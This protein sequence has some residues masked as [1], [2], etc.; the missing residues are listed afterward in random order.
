MSVMA[1]TGAP[2]ARTAA[3]GAPAPDLRRTRREKGFWAHAARRFLRNRLANLG[4]AIVSTLTFMAI[5][6]PLVTAHHYA[7][8]MFG[9]AWRFPSGEFWM[10]TDGIGRDFFSR[11]VY[12]TRVSLSVGL[13]AQL[14]SF[15]IGVPL[16]ILAGLKGGR[17]DYFIMRTVEGC[18]SFPRMLVA[19]LLM[20]L[21]GSGFGNLLL[22]IGITSWIPICRLARGEVLS[23]RERDYVLAAQAL[24]ADTFHLLV[25]HLLPN[26]LPVLLVAIS[27]GI[28]EA[29][30]TE[31]GLSFL[32]V[33]INPPTP[34]WGQMVGESV[35]YIRH[36]WHLALFPAA[37]I[38]WTML[39]FTLLGDGLRDAL[40]LKMQID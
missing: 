11:V 5:F 15:L 22:A 16:G 25:R 1:D 20:T 13:I 27:L 38:A 7:E 40:D 28:P 32:G 3:P 8:P 14:I 24:G 21:L 4:L 19:I 35:N 37:M 31:A 39:G 18:Q 23:H 36:F 30:F 10:G 2:T 26:V 9:K 6:A 33:G 17:T 12:G 34:S 29:I